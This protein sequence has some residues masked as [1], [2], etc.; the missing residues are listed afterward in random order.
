MSAARDEEMIRSMFAALLVVPLVSCALSPTTT[1]P[2]TVWY[3]ATY[4]IT[5]D[6]ERVQKVETIPWTDGLT[7]IRA[8]M[9]SGG[10]PTPPHYHIY[11]NRGGRA[12]LLPDPREMVRS[13]DDM[14]LEPG[15]RI[16]LRRRRTKL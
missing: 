1:A 6:G 5:P 11:L 9:S 14:R 16:E 2:V 12:T 4:V 8:I 7:L 13:E 10:Y 15:D 3:E